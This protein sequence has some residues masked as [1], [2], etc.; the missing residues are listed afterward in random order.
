MIHY[1]DLF[2]NVVGPRGV[3]E[4]TGAIDASG[5]GTEAPTVV[6]HASME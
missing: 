6:H 5:Q 1:D 4:G 2:I 3:S